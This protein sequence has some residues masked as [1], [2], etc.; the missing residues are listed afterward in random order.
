M[1]ALKRALN[2]ARSEHAEAS[3]AHSGPRTDFALPS[4]LGGNSREAAQEGGENDGA[5]AA[6]PPT[7][8]ASQASPLPREQQQH[9]HQHQQQQQQQQQQGRRRQPRRQAPHRGNLPSSTTARHEGC[10]SVPAERSAA[11]IID[12]DIDID[13]DTNKARGVEGSTER[14]EADDSPVATATANGGYGRGDAADSSHGAPG[15]GREP[16]LSAPPLGDVLAT[17]SHP[18]PPPSE[19]VA[20]GMPQHPMLPLPQHPTLPLP[21]PLPPEGLPPRT[22]QAE[23]RELGRDLAEAKAAADAAA[24]A[25]RGLAERRVAEL[26]EVV[27]ESERQHELARERGE[28]RLETLKRAFAQEQEEGGAHV[29]TRRS[30]D[31][32]RTGRRR[33]ATHAEP[34]AS[35]D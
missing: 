22:A 16:A 25:S 24:A 19:H 13:I 28:A 31:Y 27:A 12:I 18:R 2:S 9:Q 29:R 8:V 10:I 20:G 26:E 1:N 11:S 17:R 35:R 32:R 3:R 15:G 30:W 34:S 14:E 4:A 7:P 23:I 5:E 6:A 21:L 33:A